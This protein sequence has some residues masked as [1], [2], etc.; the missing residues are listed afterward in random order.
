VTPRYGGRRASTAP[1]T[2]PHRPPIPAPRR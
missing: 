1:R 2:C